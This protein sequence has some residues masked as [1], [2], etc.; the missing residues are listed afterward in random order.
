M[1][2]QCNLFRMIPNSYCYYALPAILITLGASQSFATS[3]LYYVCPNNI[4]TNTISA[5]EA[6][7]RGCITREAP[8][9]IKLGTKNH[10]GSSME[11][12][13]RRTKFDRENQTVE[14]WI[15]TEFK[16]PQELPIRGQKGILYS[17]S[18]QLLTFQCG[19]RYTYLVGKSFYYDSKQKIVGSHNGQVEPVLAPPDSV[20]ESMYLELCALLD[21]PK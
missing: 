19:S 7:K 14:T 6:L 10:L 20:A 4:V 21:P 1:S 18:V 11:R 12:N 13:I 8:E 3:S 2:F 15:R 9:W 17:N 16:E 5:D